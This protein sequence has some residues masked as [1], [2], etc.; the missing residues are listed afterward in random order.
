MCFPHKKNPW[1]R[2]S[3]SALRSLF[4][5]DDLGARALTLFQS[6]LQPK[7]CANY[8]SNM[9]SFVALCEEQ[10]IPFLNVTNIDL[11]Q[12]IV[13][14]GARGTVSADSL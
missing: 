7:T 12:Y 2:S 8:G 9:T 13:W 5:G 11:T 4:G 6:S 10:A 14:M 3:S 1:M